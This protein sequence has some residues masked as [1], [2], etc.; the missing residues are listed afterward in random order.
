MRGAATLLAVGHLVSTRVAACSDDAGCSLLGSCVAGSCVC[1]SG[2]TSPSCAVLNLLPARTLTPARQAYMTNRSSWGGNAIKD[3]VTGEYHLFFSE[4]RTGGLHQFSQPGH[5]QLTTAVSRLSYLGPFTNGRKVLRS[6]AVTGPTHGKISHNVQ[7]QMAADGAVYIF[8]ITTVEPRL[9]DGKNASLSVM[10]GR[11]PRLGEAFEW[12]V[13]QLL[14]PNGMKI[15]KDNPSAI[16]YGNGSVVM[17]TRGLSLFKAASWRGPYHMENPSIM[18]CENADPEVGGCKTEVTC[19]VLSH[20]PGPTMA[21]H[22]CLFLLSRSS[23]APPLSLY[24]TQQL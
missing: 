17:V 2:W 10:V 7:P 12:V 23:F 5:C 4:M 16:V 11:A 20:P 21:P 8:M 24:V 14:L 15:Y 22:I 9:Q 19:T 13:P 3:P 18:A 1:D 6:S